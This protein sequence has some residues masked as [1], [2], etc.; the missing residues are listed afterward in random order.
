MLTVWTMAGIS[1]PYVNCGLSL[2]S[3]SSVSK[4]S[5]LSALWRDAIVLFIHLTL[6][7]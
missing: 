7:R 1:Q 4:E 2:H 6:I 5:E 3:L